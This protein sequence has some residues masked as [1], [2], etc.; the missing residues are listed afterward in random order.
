MIVCTAISWREAL[1][2]NKI[3]KSRT[4]LYLVSVTC[5]FSLCIWCGAIWWCPGIPW[6]PPMCCGG[7]PVIG[8]WCMFGWCIIFTNHCRCDTKQ[9]INI[10]N[11]HQ[12][13]TANFQC[14]IRRFTLNFLPFLYFTSKLVPLLCNLHK[15]A[16]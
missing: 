12:I 16:H 13:N 4:L 7:C 6:C 5:L 10:A 1:Q 2:T 8:W 14:Q 9:T 3:M 11:C 15:S